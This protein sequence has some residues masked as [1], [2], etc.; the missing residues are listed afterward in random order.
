MQD[1]R[2]PAPAIGRGWFFCVLSRFG[3]WVQAAAAT[4]RLVGEGYEKATM[5]IA[6]RDGQEIDRLC[7]CQAEDN[8]AKWLDHLS[9]GQS[10][11]QAWEANLGDFNEGDLVVAGQIELADL[12]KCGGRPGEAARVLARLWKAIP[13]RAPT[14][15]NEK[16]TVITQ[17][18]ALL[19]RDSEDAATV[20]SA[21]RDSYTKAKD[22]NF[23]ALD[24]WVALNRVLREDD[25]TV[26]WY[27]EHKGDEWYLP[28]IRHQGPNLFLMLV[29]RDQ[30]ADAGTMISDTDRLIANWKQGHYAIADM[31]DAYAALYAAGNVKGGKDVAKAMI[32]YGDGDTACQLIRTATEAGATHGSQKAV[33][34]QCEDAPI[35]DAW[36][37]AN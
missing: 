4:A 31:F 10:M 27:N 37:A 26:A 8:Y 6:Y 13:E 2:K 20:F 16:F 33:A 12:Y 34:K 23:D 1:P 21:L 22:E 36:S 7:G 14:Y 11:A 28:L 19:A 15:Q 35:V 17:H 3:S 25:T 24:D 29:Q 18:M 32:A 9:A 30:W 5:T